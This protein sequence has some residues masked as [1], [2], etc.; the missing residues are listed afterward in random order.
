MCGGPRP[1]S[2]DR[3]T[4][5]E[6]TAS[7]WPAD[8]SSP[9]LETTIG[10]V[11]RTTA[12]QAPDRIALISG[13]PDPARR[14][15][16]TYRE[17]L[18]S[19]ERAARAL[20][21]RFAP[22][23]PVAVW[24]GN[25]PEW[26]LLEFAA[27]LAGLTLVTVNPAYQADELA[28][29]LGHSC[30]R[31]LFLAAGHRGASLP[32]ILAEVRGQLPDLR[33][34]IP[35]G[36]W[37]GF[38]A[39]GDGGPLPEVGPASAAQVLYTSGTTGRPKAAV[40]THRG[41]TNNARLAASA[42]GMR[43]GDTFVQPMPLFHIAGC[44]L[45]TLGL[46]QTR[47]THVLMP[48]FDP[49][50]VFELTET[51]RSVAVGGVA[52]M[53]TA[54]LGHPA[55]TRHDLSSVRYALS[56]GAMVPAELARQVEEVFGVPLVITFAQTESSCSITATRP[57]DSP[58]D[59]A[60]TVGR[61][62][63]QTEVKIT[64]LRTGDVVPRGAVGEI[65]TRGYLVMQGYLG[66]PDATGAAVDDDGWLHTGDLGSMDERG[67]CRIQGRIKEMIIRGGENIYPREI[68][69][70]LLSHAGVADAA[71]VGVPDRF[72]GE[73]VGAVIRPAG[74][75]PPTAAEL[76]RLCRARLA[77]YKVP[78]RWLF[79]DSFPLTSTG[80]IR[81][82]VLS[83]Q[84]ADTEPPPAPQL[85][86]TEPPPA[87]AK[88]QAV[89]QP[90]KLLLQTSGACDFDPAHL[91]D[92][93]AA[94]RRRFVTVL[95]GFGPDDW[96]APTR[97]AGWSAHHVV[98]HLADCTAIMLVSGPGDGT[99]DLAEGFDPRTT[100]RAWLAT[101]DGEPPG[102][103]LDRLV[104]TTGKLLSAARDRLRDGRRFDVRL[105]F[106]PM[107]W[108]VRLLHG[109]WDSWVHERDVLLP[110]GAGHLTDGDATAYAAGYGVFIAAAVAPM[111][112]DPVRATLRLGGDGGGTFDVGGGDAITLTVDRAATAG[113]LAAEV[114]D[115]LAGRSP[116]AVCGDVPAGLF[117]MA[118]FFNT[119]AEPRP[120]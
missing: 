98:R 71:V 120:A 92:V 119:P 105:P 24:A 64:D 118:G 19:A 25:C 11:L 102:A 60:E 48:H 27:A 28:H 104:T 8:T 114:A 58:A 2:V 37:D 69:N 110:Q 45:L 79:T 96:A 85:A 42:I 7:Y 22:G 72:W 94:Q 15:Q 31:G 87:A 14:R 18:T 86:A 21:A 61:P 13:D 81:K 68:E 53:L 44:G 95:Q 29:V 115:A 34:V 112:G 78:A 9:V 10:G 62:L 36:E 100:P 52:T 5:Q 30:A 55:R 73:E 26:V 113:P 65:C 99:L 38:C 54:L 47:G 80:K 12:V 106:G 39:S 32:D 57:A 46:V 3:M 56:G 20:R 66:D 43:D 41:L 49:V 108:T 77:A 76:A 4:H 70:V 109:F 107:D 84:L 90:G 50:L 82:D 89:P 93:F 16:W 6:L 17:L 63:P 74:P 83:A 59:R 117:R 75:Q 101:S 23:E 111:F 40:L 67:Y 51:Y 1:G 88:T 116:A 91:L 33:E 103:S 97:C 35:F